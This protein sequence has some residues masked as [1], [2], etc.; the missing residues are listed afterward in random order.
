MNWEK[1]LLV[2]TQSLTFLGLSI[3]SQTMSLSLP[4]KKI[5]DIQN[6][7]QSLICNPTTSARTVAR[8]IGT[9]EVAHP[10]TWQA[11][12]HYSQLQIQLIKSLQASRDNY[13]ILVSLNSNAHFKLQ[14]WLHNIA[15]VKGNT[16]N[17]PAAELYITSDASKEGWGACCQN[18]IANGRLS[19]LEAKDHINVI[20]LKAVFSC[21]QNLSQ[22][23]FQ[24]QCVF[25]HGQHHSR[26]SRVQ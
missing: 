9:L 18:L 8:L 23:P 22:T 7:C 14:W 5:L 21:N 6:K 26:F 24:H 16:V 13:E 3:D 15:T 17:P 12:L 2:P 20:E 25:P 1:S 19:P 4:E 11:P 10:A